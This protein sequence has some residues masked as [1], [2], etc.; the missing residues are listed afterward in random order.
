[1]GS[2]ALEGRVS[3]MSPSYID[4][5]PVGGDR[6]VGARATQKRRWDQ[7]NL[8]DQCA[9]GRLKWAQYSRCSECRAADVEAKRSR[10]R[11][12]R[13]EHPHLS[14]RAIARIVGCSSMMAWR[15]VNE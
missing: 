3:L 13:A 14:Y 8:R 9:C 10:A 11:T 6:R 7:D 15:Y 1:M 2:T 4:R 5:K 12:L